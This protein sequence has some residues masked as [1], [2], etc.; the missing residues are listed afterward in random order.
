MVYESRHAIGLSGP[1]N[2]ELLIH[3]GIDTVELKGSCFD[4]K[5]KNGESVKQGQLLMK[6]D[7]ER[8]RKAGYRTITP[9]VIT[10]SAAFSDI[11]RTEKQKVTCQDMILEIK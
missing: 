3:V 5:V 4:V 11:L 10:N 8:I 7:L 9:V 1:G 2:V 6:A